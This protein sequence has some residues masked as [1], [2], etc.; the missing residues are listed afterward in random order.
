MWGPI[1]LDYLSNAFHIYMR[2]LAGVIR[3]CG[4]SCHQY[5]DDTE[6]YIS[7]F[8]TT[9]DAVSSLE[10]CLGAVQQ[11]MQDNGLRLKLGKTQVLRVGGSSIGGLGNSLS[12][13]G[14]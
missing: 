3:G 9:V 1:G 8:P 12:F 5:T 2:P 14:G 11:W 6:L 10:R 4:A 13:L 7:F